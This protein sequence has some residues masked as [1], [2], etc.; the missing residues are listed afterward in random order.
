MRTVQSLGAKNR[1]TDVA[2]LIYFT[3]MA[4]FYIKTYIQLAAQLSILLYVAYDVFIVRK[5]KKDKKAGKENVKFFVLWFGLFAGFAALSTRWAY[6][7]MANS[8]TILTL[9]RMF[10]IGVAIM[11]YVSNYDRA[12]SVMKAFIFSNVVMAVAALVTT[13]FSQYGKA[14]EEGF[15]VV[16]GQQRNTFGAVMSFVVLICIILYQYDRFKYG[17]ILAAFFVCA[18]LCSGSRGAMLQLVIIA[19]LYVI[20]IPGLIKKLKYVS[21]AILVAL[22]AVVVLQNVPYLYETVWVRFINMFSTVTG[23][24]AQADGSALGREL[25]K[26]LAWDMF[27]DRPVL[28]H[29]VDGFYCMLRDVEYIDGYYVPPRYSHCNFAEIGANFG[30]IGLIIWYVPVFGIIWG[31]FKQRT[32]S[33]QMNMIFIVLTSMVILDYARIPW[34]NHISM[35]TYFCLFALYLTA[36]R[37]MPKKRYV[38]E[39]GEL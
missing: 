3:V 8:N 23:I 10:V 37:Q 11:L 33:P 4:L 15:G 27:C 17:K 9:T 39:F 5:N 31:S 35:Y 25:Y 14:G 18:L 36:K 26:V 21:T 2:F 38:S 34:A 32:K 28:G 22:A 12:V 19:C 20:T 1:K 24:N 7:V 6:S 29:G 16:I 13:P 30:L